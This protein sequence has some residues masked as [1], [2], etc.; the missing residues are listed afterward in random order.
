MIRRYLWLPLTFSALLIGLA[1]FLGEVRNVLSDG[2]AT[3]FVLV[4]SIL[5]ATAI[6]VQA[7]MALVRI[8]DQRWLRYGMLA[9][10][11]TMMVVQLWLWVRPRAE[12]TVVERIHFIFYSVLAVL[13]Y[14]SFSHRRDLSGVILT[15][16]AAATVGTLDEGMQWLVPVRVASFSDVLLNAYSVIAGIFLGIAVI[17]VPDGWRPRLDGRSMPAVAMGTAVFLLVVG[18]YLQ[19]AHLGHLV[20]DPAFGSFH[21]LHTQD[22]LRRLAAE[23]AESWKR[24]PPGRPSDLTV[25]EIEDYY[26]SE[27]GWHVHQRNRFFSSGDYA[28]ASKETDLLE[29]YFDPFLDLP[30]NAGR[31]FR[32]GRNQRKELEDGL[33][34]Q[35]VELDSSWISPVGRD[36]AAIFLRPTAAE[37]WL[38]IVGVVA[39]LG[40]LAWR[41]RSGSAASDRA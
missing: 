11:A 36:P 39:A 32:F 38:G 16:L 14:R 21:S 31:P 2:L 7:V 37:L 4:M 29:A 15:F 18:G 8:E 24:D 9:I 10:W 33:I 30:N 34:Q 13:F 1:P 41:S 40:A 6:A 3:R 17:G 5:F 35:G 27:A 19:V 23:R 25:F 28:Q 22:D 26:R 20:V 12:V